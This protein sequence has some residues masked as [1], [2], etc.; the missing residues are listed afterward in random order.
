AATAAGVAV[1]T[2]ARK[3]RRSGASILSRAGR[4]FLLSLAPPIVAGA[5]LTPALVEGGLATRLPGA[6]LLLY[7][8]GVVTGGAF[9]IRIVPVMGLAFM[10]AG[11]AAL[12]APGLDPDWV[13]AAG[14][15]GLHLV[16]GAVIARRHGG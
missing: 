1:A 2:T 4:R 9:S 12:A 3:A 7:G 13:M 5:L 8:A 10:V 11:A 15:G 6:W 16:F 14:F